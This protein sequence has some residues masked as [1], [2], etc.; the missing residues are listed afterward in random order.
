[1]LVVVPD[2]AAA[3]A[4]VPAVVGSLA[5]VTG[6]NADVVMALTIIVVVCCFHYSKSL[7]LV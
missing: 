7:L 2:H 5:A 4:S 1:M 3:V 6:P